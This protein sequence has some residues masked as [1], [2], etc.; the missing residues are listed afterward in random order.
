MNVSPDWLSG[1]EEQDWAICIA[2]Y[3]SASGVYKGMI[4]TLLC[5][6]LHSQPFYF[7]V[8]ACLSWIH[9]QPCHW[10]D[11]KTGTAADTSMNHTVKYLRFENTQDWASVTMKENS[12]DPVDWAVLI[13]SFTKGTYNWAKEVILIVLGKKKKK[14]KHQLSL[15]YSL[16]SNKKEW[17]LQVQ[18]NFS[19]LY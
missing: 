16:G 14:K 18:W 6:C 17:I 19:F 15:Q 7:P 1:K 2:V 3:V 10:P 4:K 13:T 8:L 5:S 11:L 9:T 12:L